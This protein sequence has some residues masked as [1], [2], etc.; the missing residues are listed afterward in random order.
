MQQ[1]GGGN[2]ITGLTELLAQAERCGNAP[3]DLWN[4]P[5][6]GDIGL[7]I[8]ADGVWHYRESPIH[9]ERL[10][11]LFARVLRREENGRHYLVTPVEKVDVHVE[12]AAFIAVEMECRGAGPDQTL[13]FR[14]N[15]DDVVVCGP[16]RPLRFQLGPDGSCRPYVVVRGRLEALVSRA[17]THDLLQLAIETQTDGGA[18]GIWSDGAF[19]AIAE[20]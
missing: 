1:N 17:L 7:K 2:R 11:K 4:P 13:V 20:G 10:V 3:V 18:I 5:Y 14:T 6:C 9:R 8:T 16:Q 12:D 15:L 19:F